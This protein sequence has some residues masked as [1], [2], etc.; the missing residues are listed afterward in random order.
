MKGNLAALE[1]AHLV[2]YKFWGDN[3]LDK[4]LQPALGCNFNYLP[5]QLIDSL[6]LRSLSY[7]EPVLLIRE[8]YELAFQYLKAQEGKGQDIRSGGVVITGQPGIGTYLSLSVISFAK[9][10]LV[11]DHPI[12]GSLVSCI[13]F[14]FVSWSSRRALHFNW[15]TSSFY[16]RIPAFKF[17][18][19]IL[20]AEG[21]CLRAHGP[22]L[23]H[24]LVLNSPVMRF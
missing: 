4:Q 12:Q 15:T 21:V 20:P 3:G 24:T 2:Y 16:F 8:E 10:S 1:A 17:Q 13:T 22:F 9:N 18:V 14:S 6:K 5:R 23:I 19:P 11:S 7:K